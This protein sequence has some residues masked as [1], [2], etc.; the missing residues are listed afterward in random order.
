MRSVSINSVLRRQSAVGQAL[1]LAACW[2]SV[3][4]VLRAASTTSLILKT[5]EG[6]V[7]FYKHT[8]PNDDPYTSNPTSSAIQFM[9]TYW[10]RM[11]TFS[12]YWD[13]NNK[14]SW[15]PNAWTYAD[16]YAIYNDP[17]NPFWA[18]VVQQ[19]P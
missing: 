15:Y 1:V 9:N 8:S 19:H 14:L 17:T 12:G 11:L 2:G 3:P 7:N 18:Q 10:L 6:H 16:S 4:P 13:Q 5:P